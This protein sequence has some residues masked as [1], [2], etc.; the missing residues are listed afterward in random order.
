MNWGEGGKIDSIL[1]I[2]FNKLVQRPFFLILF[3]SFQVKNYCINFAGAD[4]VYH[5]IDNFLL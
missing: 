2:T 1:M 4:V 5:M 3:L